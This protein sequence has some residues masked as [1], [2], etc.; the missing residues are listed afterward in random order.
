MSDSVAETESYISD[1]SIPTF[2]LDY[3]DTYERLTDI[4]KE[5]ET[6]SDVLR[7]ARAVRLTYRLRK[8]LTSQCIIKNVLDFAVPKN[9]MLNAGLSAYLSP[10][11]TIQ[12]QDDEEDGE[13]DIAA[14]V[15]ALHAVEFPPELEFYCYFLVLIFLIDQGKD[16]EAK[17][18]ST[19]GLYRLMT[20]GLNGLELATVG[21]LAHRLY[22][23]FSYTHEVL[24][25]DLAEIRWCLFKLH[26]IA[27]MV[28]DELGQE[29]LINLLLR[30][31]LHYKLYDQA[32]KLMSMAP[33]SQPRSTQQ[34]CR[35][36]FYRG[37]IRTIQL[38]YTDAKESL[39]QAA[40]IVPVSARGFLIQCNKW[41]VLVRLLLGEIPER[42]IFI[43]SGM[44]GALRPY[45]ELTNAVRIGDLELFS[46]VAERFAGIFKSD[47]TNHVIFRLRHSVIMVGLR[48][49]SISYSRISLADVANKLKMHSTTHVADVESIV[50]KAIRDGIINAIIDHANGW[51][52]LKKTE[53]IYSTAE[54]QAAFTS[55]IAFCLNLHN[56]AVRA[57][58]LPKRRIVLRRGKKQVKYCME[59]YLNN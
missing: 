14:S 58:R 10:E 39:L 18:C 20:M 53:D 2:M 33:N 31:Y 8:K 49:I 40:Q 55:R 7:T 27:I 1:S 54:P 43:R 35:Y 12:S 9:S 24:D 32:W 57:L 25:V 21:V 45:F 41:A 17:D 34:L 47:R 44:Q 6:S 37:K 30:N 5:I 36:L 11:A 22:F 29:T 19:D 13:D 50:A 51:L 4:I 48:N 28:H 38:E 23:Y 15:L 59:N 26:H 52:V 46:N 3:F 16:L 42:T 56:K